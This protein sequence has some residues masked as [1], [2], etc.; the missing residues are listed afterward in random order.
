MSSDPQYICRDCEAAI[1]WDRPSGR[2]VCD[3]CGPTWPKPA[4]DHVFSPSNPEGKLVIT[5]T[6]DTPCSYCDMPRRSH[7]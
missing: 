7:H 1:R 2:F 4:D 3:S 6:A 5:I